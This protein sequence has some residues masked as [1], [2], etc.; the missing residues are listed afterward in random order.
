VPWLGPTRQGLGSAHARH[1]R[2]HQ[3]AVH[4]VVTQHG[5]PG[6]VALLRQPAI[7]K[8]PGPIG[9]V[10]RLQVHDQKRNVG[11]H[12]DPA[13]CGIEL[14]GIEGLWLPFQQHQIAQVQVAVAFAH[15][16]RQAPGLEHGRQGR[17]LLLAPG[18]QRLQCWHQRRPT[19]IGLGLQ[20]RQTVAHRSLYRPGRAPALRGT[21]HCG[22]GMEA[23]DFAC[24]GI[25]V[26]P[27]QLPVLQTLQ[28]Q[29]V[30][31]KAAHANGWLGVLGGLPN[32][33]SRRPCAAVP[34]SPTSPR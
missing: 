30:L 20:G 27:A 33:C 1:P 31:R 34:D 10:T 24:Q 17:A 19:A 15:P 18:G 29:V 21:G 12:I 8:A 28:Q 23:G 16:P 9:P 4:G 6:K 22:R 11:H 3:G 14:D 32:G 26:C 2:T 25:H 7:Q 13:Q 5:H